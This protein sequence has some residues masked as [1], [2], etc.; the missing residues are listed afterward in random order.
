VSPQ[1]P[2]KLLSDYPLSEAIPF[3]TNW[4]TRYQKANTVVS[5]QVF[6]SQFDLNYVAIY[7]D[8]PHLPTG[9][10]GA[11]YLFTGTPV[12]HTFVGPS[13]WAPQG[14]ARP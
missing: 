10:A 13:T 14:R 3:Y 2:L 4:V 5:N 1:D 6:F 8:R 9:S 7:S 12:A 11:S